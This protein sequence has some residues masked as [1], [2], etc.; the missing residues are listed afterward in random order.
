MTGGLSGGLT[1]GF[2][3]LNGRVGGGADAVAAGVDGFLLQQDGSRLLLES[4][5]ALLLE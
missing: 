3:G 1:A 2:N 4:G 5:D